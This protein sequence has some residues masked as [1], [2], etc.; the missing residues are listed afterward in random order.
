MMPNLPNKEQRALVVNEFLETISHYTKENLIQSFMATYKYP[1]IYYL[2]HPS[3]LNRKSLRVGQGPQH[4]SRALLFTDYFVFITKWADDP[5]KR[6]S[7]LAWFAKALTVGTLA[8]YLGD[9]SYGITELLTAIGNKFLSSGKLLG[10]Q[11][12]PE[13]MNPWSLIIPLRD[14][15][16]CEN[17]KFGFLNL[18]EVLHISADIR[19]EGKR[20][21]YFSI[22]LDT[23]KWYKAVSKAREA[24]SS[25]QSE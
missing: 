16:V 23:Y 11:P 5:Q 15:K 10:K 17:V 3:N 21:G 12:L 19:H 2:D 7:Y 1:A 18:G 4:D 25:K 22:G 9:V 20:E 6:K 8:D 14:I 13:L 24:C